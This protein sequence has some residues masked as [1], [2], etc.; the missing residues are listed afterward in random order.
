MVKILI[1]VPSWN[2]PYEI[3]NDTGFWLKQLSSE[4]DWI[5][6]VE[7]SQHAYY[8]QGIPRTHLITSKDSC[9][10]AGQCN[11]I[12][13]YAK[14]NGFTHIWRVDDD[15]FFKERATKKK[16]TAK[17]V[18]KH[19][20]ILTEF[21]SKYNEIGG[22]A[23]TRPRTIMFNKDGQKFGGGGALLCGSSVYQ[24]EGMEEIPKEVEEFDDLYLTI[25]VNERMK[26]KTVRYMN[27][28]LCAKGVTTNNAGGMNTH[29]LDERDKRARRSFEEIKKVFPKVEEWKDTKHPH[30][31]MKIDAYLNRFSVGKKSK[32]NLG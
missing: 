19:C 4:I 11:R 28:A 26:L 12:L 25:L 10:I 17:V 15:S 13:G 3:E 6:C 14:E 1:A 2:R 22:I 9:G 29:G 7:P 27:L 31:D 16:E 18:E 5:V 23:F 24:I 20:Q 8:A 32:Y 21:L 30:F